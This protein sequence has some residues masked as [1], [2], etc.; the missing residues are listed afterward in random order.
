MA[1]SRRN[2]LKSGIMVAFSAAIPLKIADIAVGQQSSSNRL[3]VP[4]TTFQIPYA[5]QSDPVFYFK[6]STFSPYVNTIFGLYFTP[7]KVMSTRLIRVADAG[8]VDGRKQDALA[9]RECFSLLFRAPLYSKPLPDKIYQIEHGALGKFKMFL[10]FRGKDRYGL[11]Y[12][13]IINH[14]QA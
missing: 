4:P 1:L 13:A 11:N 10:T 5:S 8:P 7:Q 9:G 12:E 6:K 2:F 14:R 3:T